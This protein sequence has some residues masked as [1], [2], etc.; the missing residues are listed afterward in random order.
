MTA[1]LVYAL[2]EHVIIVIIFLSLAYAI[3]VGKGH[4]FH[5]FKCYNFV[6]IFTKIKDKV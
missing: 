2:V 3:S 4:N 1:I 5:F 6:Y